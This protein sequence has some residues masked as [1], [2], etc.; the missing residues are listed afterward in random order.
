[1]PQNRSNPA[2]PIAATG[3]AWYT[4]ET[5]RQCLAIFEDASEFPETFDQWLEI[6]ERT[7]RDEQRKGVRVIRV[8]INPKTFRDD[9]AA[10]GHIHATGHACADFAGHKAAEIL[11][12]E[13]GV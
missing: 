5:Y 3:I 12:R 1:M 13:S 11:Q 6:A 10:L 4:R 8:E 7:E 9:C 2:I